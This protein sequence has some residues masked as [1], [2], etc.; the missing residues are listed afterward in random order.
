VAG[1]FSS[2]DAG[3]QVHVQHNQL[4]RQQEEGQADGSI[5]WMVVLR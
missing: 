4:F 5:I 2:F 3:N 1:F